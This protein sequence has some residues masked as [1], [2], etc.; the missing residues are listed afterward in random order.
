MVSHEAEYEN[1]NSANSLPGQISRPP[2]TPSAP[3]RFVCERKIPRK[4]A[5]VIVGGRRV[6]Y[7]TTGWGMRPGPISRR[8]NLN[9]C[10]YE[11]GHCVGKKW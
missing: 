3:R 11:G 9:I 5:T 4:W 1:P 7:S 2:W 6:R 8:F 10:A